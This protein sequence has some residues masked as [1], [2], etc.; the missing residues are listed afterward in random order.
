ME[1]AVNRL[2]ADDS[3]L[4]TSSNRRSFFVSSESTLP[5]N[6]DQRRKLET[7]LRLRA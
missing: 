5:F 2:L 1:F 6:P 4:L 3:Y 7:S